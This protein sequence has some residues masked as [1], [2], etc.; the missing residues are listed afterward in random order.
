M[1]TDEIINYLD[2]KKISDNKKIEFIKSLDLS[3]SDLFVLADRYKD[4]GSLHSF[5][6][7]LTYYTDSNLELQRSRQKSKTVAHAKNKRLKKS[8]R[9]FER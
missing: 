3:Y 8:K 9:R 7:G 6:Y 5:I 4:C 1:I 2:S